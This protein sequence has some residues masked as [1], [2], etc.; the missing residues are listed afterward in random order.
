M[1]AT[2]SRD[3]KIWLADGSNCTGQ[4]DIRATAIAA[5]CRPSSTGRTLPPTCRMWVTGAFDSV[6]T[7]HW[8]S[9]RAWLAGSGTARGQ[10]MSPPEESSF[11]AVSESVMSTLTQPP[12]RA[13]R[14]AECLRLPPATPILRGTRRR[15]ASGIPTTRASTGEAIAVPSSSKNRRHTSPTAPSSRSLPLIARGDG[16]SRFLEQGRRFET[17]DACEEDG[18]ARPGLTGRPDVALVEDCAAEYG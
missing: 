3:L 1:D 6:F 13:A 7:N 11:A 10:A 9:G 17:P 16:V 18:Q 12:R 5:S 14:I 2:G 8:G 15:T 4:V